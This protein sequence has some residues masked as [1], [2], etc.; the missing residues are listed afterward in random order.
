MKI[1]ISCL[2]FIF[3]LVTIFVF[4]TLYPLSLKRLPNEYVLQPP[5]HVLPPWRRR[6]ETPGS[7]RTGARHLSR[8][9]P[10]PE[11]KAGHGLP[12]EHGQSQPVAARR[13][14]S[15]LLSGL[16]VAATCSPRS[17]AVS[18]LLG[19]RQREAVD[20]AAGLTPDEH[21]V[22][23]PETLWGVKGDLVII[24]QDCFKRT[25]LGSIPGSASPRYAFG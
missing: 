4:V 1:V 17:P 6:G 22:C 19:T 12:E 10:G 15:G 8:L 14:P 13:G 18:R 7:P 21:T 25:D 20:G 23:Y 3:T 24:C 9:P 2:I 16:L 11:P 5:Q